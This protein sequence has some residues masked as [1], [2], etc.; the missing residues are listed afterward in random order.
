MS[1]NRVKKLINVIDEF[2]GRYRFL[3]NFHPALVLYEGI[4]YRSV[5]HAFQAAKTK[6]SMLR[7][8]IASIP[9]PGAAK[10]A[11]NKLIL[12]GGWDDMKDQI[13][14]DL[15]RIK[16]SPADQLMH[17][18]LIKTGDVT[19]IEG[20]YWHDN[21]WGDCFCNRCKCVDGKNKLGEI[22]MKVRGE[23]ANGKK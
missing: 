19:L 1:T 15:V 14:L 5:E 8:A 22:L 10:R 23:L 13:M 3:S 12:R 21:Y 6:D 11:G 4:A 9:S 17:M 20:N 2:E 18:L 7:I 16:F